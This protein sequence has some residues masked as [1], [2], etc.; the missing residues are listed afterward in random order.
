MIFNTRYFFEELKSRGEE[1]KRDT[2]KPEA[3]VFGENPTDSTSLGADIAG[4]TSRRVMGRMGCGLKQSV[5][6]TYL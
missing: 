2:L 3:R 1:A 6:S 5:E 4:G